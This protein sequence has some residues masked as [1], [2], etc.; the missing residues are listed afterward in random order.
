ML[1]KSEPNLFEIKQIVINGTSDTI[2]FIIHFIK[3]SKNKNILK[4]IFSKPEIFSFE[5]DFEIK[6]TN[7]VAEDVT[8]DI[9]E[10]DAAKIVIPFEKFFDISGKLF[11]IHARGRFK[12]KYGDLFL[13]DSEQEPFIKN[14]DKIVYRTKIVVFSKKYAAE[15][16]AF[17][18]IPFRQLFPI[19][20]IAPILL[21]SL[22]V[23]AFRHLNKEKL[24]STL[25]TRREM[26]LEQRWGFKPELLTDKITAFLRALEGLI[27]RRYRE[28]IVATSEIH[29]VQVTKVN[30]EF[31]RIQ[32]GLPTVFFR[33]VICFDYTN[34]ESNVI[35]ISISINKKLILK[36]VKRLWSKFK[37]PKRTAPKKT[38]R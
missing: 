13:I 25:H 27:S 38:L 8:R 32:Q 22:D 4:R 7:S 23:K 10:Y 24:R 6:I 37:G 5:K 28:F 35:N 19:D 14:D 20:F 29:R 31:S 11:I 18:G 2:D 34:R 9:L 16:A 36:H 21:T 15:E 17:I 30:V 12:Q 1:S 26:A 3:A 33:P